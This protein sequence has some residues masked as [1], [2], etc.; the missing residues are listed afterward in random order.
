MWCSAEGTPPISISLFK[1]SSH[2][3]SGTGI[4]IS[5]INQEGN[6]TCVARNE[7]GTDAIDF[8]VTVVGKITISVM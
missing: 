6:Y 5:K 4:V 8:Q 7:A 1:S 3:A 2:L